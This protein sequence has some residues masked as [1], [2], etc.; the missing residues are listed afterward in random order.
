MNL[1]LPS[2]LVNGAIFYTLGNYHI[3]KYGRNHLFSLLGVSALAGTILSA[4]SVYR[5][6][7]FTAKGSASLSAGLLGYHLMKNPQ[8]F[9][10]RK[11]HIGYLSLFVLYAAFYQDRAAFS[12]FGAGYLFFLLGL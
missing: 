3:Q 12:G 11:G 6:P 8:W 2:L 7:T 10:Y 5:D 1:E 4:Y 9:K